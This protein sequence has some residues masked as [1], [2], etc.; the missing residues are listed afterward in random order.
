MSKKSQKIVRDINGENNYI[1]KISACI[2]VKN[3]DRLLKRCLVSLKGVV[4]EIILVHD[5]KCSD[6]SLE[7]GRSFG[8]KAFEASNENNCN[9]HRPL[10]FELAKNDWILQ[11]DADEF[12]SKKLA[13]N[14]NKLVHNDNVDA[15]EFLWP[16]WKKSRYITKTWPYKKC[17]F[18]KKKLSYLGI[19]N[20][21]PEIDG[22]V[23]R[24]DYLLEHR[25][26]NYNFSISTLMSKFK[27]RARLQAQMYLQDFSCIKNFN[28]DDSNWPV[29][30]RMRIKFPL[31]LI[32]LEFAVTFYKNLASGAWREGLVGFRLSLMFGYYRM[33]VNYYI[34]KL[35]LKK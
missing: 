2:V 31:L 33:L 25:P 10:S 30:I 3:E 20:F 22:K 15:Y 26:L 23:K 12:L 24:I 28:R 17:L 16:I 4:D 9:P 1:N 11:I 18:R 29:Q 19:P 8:A 5:G 35:K 14:L 32:P 13:D 34:F 7:V 6:N 27:H 21:V